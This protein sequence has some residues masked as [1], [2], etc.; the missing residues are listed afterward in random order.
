MHVLGGNKAVLRTRLATV[1]HEDDI[2]VCYGGT[3][4]RG[5]PDSPDEQSLRTHVEACIGG[6]E[7]SSEGR[8]EGV[9]H[10]VKGV[11]KWVQVQEEEGL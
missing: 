1:M 9:W 6:G 3:C 11:L 4:T 2:S 5:L 8:E 7:S 10:A